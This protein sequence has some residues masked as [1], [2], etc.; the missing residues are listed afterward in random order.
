MMRFEFSYTEADLDEWGKAK[1][2]HKTAAGSKAR[3]G[4]FGWLVFLG[5]AAV[6][7]KMMRQDRISSPSPATSAGGEGFWI[8]FALPFLPWVLVFGV[9]WFFVFRQF[10]KQGR[11]IWRDNEDL[12]E[13]HVFVVDDQGIEV[14]GP[15]VATRFLWAAF[16]GWA[17]T[18]NLFL[19]WQPAGAY[20]IL[21]KRAATEAEWEQLRSAFQAHLAPKTGGF[22]VL[23]GPPTVGPADRRT[24]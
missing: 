20:T 12:L 2:P 16:G 1:K 19:V 5:L 24:A 23:V 6:L 7:V 8:D 13:P 15:K 11:R 9:I 17:E 18:A 22:P 21:P 4:L 3:K 14:R 10:R